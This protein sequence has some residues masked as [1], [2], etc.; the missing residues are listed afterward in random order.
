MEKNNIY[1]SPYVRKKDINNKSYRKKAYID[2][3]DL[4][5]TFEFNIQVNL[6]EHNIIENI[7]IKGFE[8]TSEIVNDA[9]HKEIRFY[10]ENQRSPHSERPKK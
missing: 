3:E 5:G 9:A 6:I 8:T 2:N 10:N 4:Y 7:Q 1:V